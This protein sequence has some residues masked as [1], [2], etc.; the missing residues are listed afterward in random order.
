[1]R[2]EH[3]KTAA[4][5][6]HAV[7]DELLSRREISELFKISQMTVI[8]MEQRGDLKPIRVGLRSIRYRASDVRELLINC[9]SKAPA[10]VGQ[11]EQIVKQVLA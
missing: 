3:I 9:A 4:R 11:A 5:N 8:R 7:Q 1:M 2:N 6:M 10:L